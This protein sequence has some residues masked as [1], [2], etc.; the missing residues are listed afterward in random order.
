MKT[1]HFL[2]DKI[3]APIL[4]VLLI[5]IIIG[6]ILKNYKGLLCLVCNDRGNLS[7]YHQM[8]QCQAI[9]EMLN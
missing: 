7:S 5:P 1:V 6:T 3:V 8:V 4:A 9:G 2:L